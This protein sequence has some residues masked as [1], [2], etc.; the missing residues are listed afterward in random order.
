MVFLR[1]CFLIGH[2]VQKSK[3]M[4]P[5]PKVMCFLDAAFHYH[6]TTAA[7]HISQIL[8]PRLQKYLCSPLLLKNDPCPPICEEY[9]DSQSVHVIMKNLLLS[10]WVHLERTR[11]IYMTQLDHLQD[12]W[13]RQALQR[14]T[15]GRAGLRWCS[16]SNHS[17]SLLPV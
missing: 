15:Q 13:S 12:H 11:C 6:R 3:T 4:P 14:A 17:G 5:M 10:P 7:V 8:Q 2:P 1:S 16:F 9:N